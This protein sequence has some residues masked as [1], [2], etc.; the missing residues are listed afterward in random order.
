MPRVLVFCDYYADPLV[1]G[2]ER[3]T[4]EI[5]RR[6]DDDDV[7]TLVV[8][9]VPGSAP[10]APPGPPVRT[11]R[12][13]DLSKLVGAQLAVAPSLPFVGVSAVRRHRPDVVYAASIHFVGSIVAAVLSILTRTPLVTAVHLAGI[14]HLPR[15]VR[16]LTA[17]YERTFGWM[18]LRRSASVLAVS[19]AAAE[20]AVRR[21]ARPDRLTV[22]AN[23]VDAELFRPTPGHDAPPVIAVVGRLVENKGTLETAD[24]IRGLDAEVKVVFAGSGPLEH[25]LRERCA[26]DDRL[27][28]IGQTDAV[29]EVLGPADIFVR[30]ST[31][32]GQSLAVL[33]AMACGCAVVV[34][35]IPANRE[36][37]TDGV[38][39]LVVPL[40]DV[41][42]LREAIER[43]VGD[44]G[45]RRRIAAAAREDALG[46]SWGAA[47]D[48]T[49]AALTGASQS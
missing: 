17:L 2:A 29:H 10:V 41:D 30:Y 31:T 25:E 9:G 16:W 38:N 6:L 4:H 45:L 22:V 14:D 35:D 33:E 37:V 32:E 5:F 36:L 7:D 13:I 3:V 46:H 39:G 28:W 48:A 47:A 42:A 20:H 40:G 49:V 27:E 19:E 18:I 8:S 44:A 34:S 15:R 11:C 24:A 26:A 12:A 23:G 21:G 43:L 1:G